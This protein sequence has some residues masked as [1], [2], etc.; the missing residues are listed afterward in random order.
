[1]SENS[2]DKKNLPFSEL[3]SMV[4]YLKTQGRRT[5]HCR[6]PL[7]LEDLGLIGSRNNSYEQIENLSFELADLRDLLSIWLKWP[8]QERYLQGHY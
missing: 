4:A 5:V 3:G 7:D 2:I 6:W 8:Y 1:M